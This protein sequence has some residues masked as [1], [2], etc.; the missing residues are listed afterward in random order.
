MFVCCGRGNAGGISRVLTHLPINQEGS[1]GLSS[2]INIDL[3]LLKHEIHLT[4]AVANGPHGIY[5]VRSAKST[6][7]VRRKR[8]PGPACPP[9]AVSALVD[10]SL[11]CGHSSKTTPIS[12]PRL[13]TSTTTTT[14]RVLVRVRT[15][16]RLSQLLCRLYYERIRL[17]DLRPF[18]N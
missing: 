15:I 3:P 5:A 8:Q 6:T 18:M 12:C 4:T 17:H 14:S 9:K 13:F 2:S 16:S 1:S 11:L 7:V 10:S